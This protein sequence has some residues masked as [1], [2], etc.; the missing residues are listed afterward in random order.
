MTQRILSGLFG[1]TLLALSAGAQAQVHDP[2]Y[3]S[4]RG[5]HGQYG[6]SGYYRGGAYRGDIIDQ[7]SRDV[8][9]AAANSRV[10]GHERGHFNTVQ[11]E[12]FNFQQRWAQGRIDTGRLDKVIGALNDLAKSDQVMPR[13]RQILAND[14]AALRNFRATG[15]QSYGGPYGTY[16]PYNGS[17]PNTGPYRN[18]SRN[19]DPHGDHDD[20]H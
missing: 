14:L 19:P 3:G 16:G 2:Y 7:V 12:L 11:R 10:D 1:L 20:H 5:Q 17:Y 8:S 4:Q 6:N 9:L 15:G 18:H 13:D